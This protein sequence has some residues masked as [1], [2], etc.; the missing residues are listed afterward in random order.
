M[1]DTLNVG[2]RLCKGEATEGQLHE[3]S[4]SWNARKERLTAMTPS[5]RIQQPNQRRL[6]DLVFERLV[7]SQRPERIVRD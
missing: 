3:G 5:K 7:R 4:E 6:R 1:G 2:E